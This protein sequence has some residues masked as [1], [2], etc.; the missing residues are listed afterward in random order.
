MNMDWKEHF[1]RVSNPSEFGGT[2]AQ[3][4]FMMMAT[5]GAIFGANYDGN[6]TVVKEVQTAINA[7]GYTPALVVDGEYGPKTT[8]GVK[9]AQTKKGIT[10]DGIIGD[11]TLSALGIASPGGSSPTP[12]PASSGGKTSNVP[13][14]NI[15]TVVAALK[16]AASEKGYTISDSLAALMIGQLRGA[17]G[18]YP[19]VNSSLGGTNNMGASQVTKSFATAKQ[20][21]EGWGAFAHKDSDPNSGSY[22]GFYW[23]APT[24]IDAARHWFQD[25]WWG[26][27]LAKGN[28]S[29]PTSYSSILYQGK[30]FAGMHPGDP[31]HDPTSDAGKQNVADYAAAIKRGMP[32]AAE[33]SAPVGDVNAVTVDPTKFATLDKRGITEDLYNK[34]MSGGIGSAWK[35]LLPTT[36]DDFSKANGVIWFGTP[37]KLSSPAGKFGMGTLVASIIGGVAVLWWFFTKK[38]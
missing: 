1:K 13:S 2:D 35:F 33:M 38:A 34:A 21:L 10:S 8:A 25:N 12:N 31:N 11:Q 24:V 4:P 14:V 28:P 6:Q 27:A 29:D 16:Q 23:I 22:I 5:F 30:Y 36:W 37:P 20:G 15:A 7:M 3:K 32:S 26:P 18:A 19:G 9:W 17:E